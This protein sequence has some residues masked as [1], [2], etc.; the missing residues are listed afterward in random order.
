MAKQTGTMTA[1]V[2]MGHGG[3]DQIEVR[4]DWPRPVAE[5]GHVVVRVA[6]AAINNTDIWS[7][8]GAYGTAGDPDAVAGWRGVPLDFPRIQGIDVV[9]Y[10]DSVGQDVP[11]RWL[12]RRV[13]VDSAVRYE[14]DRPAEIVGSEVDGG[15]AEFHACAEAQLHDMTGSPLSDAQLSCVPTAYGTALGMI[16]RAGC[17]AGERVLVTGA[18]GG[19][20]MA[21][22]Q[23]LADRG[24]RVVARTSDGKQDVV[25]AAGADEVSLRGADSL[26][27]VELVDVVV[28][29]V[30]GEEFGA[31]V[32]RLRDG[33]RLVTAG[34][35]A[36]PVVPLDLRRLYLHHRTLIGSTMHT[37]ADF[38]ELARIAVQGGIAPVVAESFSLTDI[39]RAQARFLEKDFVGKLVLVP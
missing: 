18:S 20:G 1:A 26:A 37:P 17:A 33:G 35:I 27:A 8:E 36:G 24:C 21:A 19:V 23:L 29:V 10:I 12:D 11:E 6:A 9:G 7:R 16:N 14:D 32:D 22:V 3:P 13:L 38:A 31:A 5:P 28:D 4:T 25:K 34:A 30:G 2:T 15:F 39:A